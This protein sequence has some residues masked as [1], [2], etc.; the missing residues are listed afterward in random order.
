[1]KG[2]TIAVCNISGFKFY[3]IFDES[4]EVIGTKVVFLSESDFGGALPKWFT[5]HFTPKGIHD[6]YDDMV[7]LAK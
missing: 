3:P 1:M 2:M 4:G 6:F 7:K 5:S